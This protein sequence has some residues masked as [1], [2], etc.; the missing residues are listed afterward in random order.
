MIEKIFVE[1]QGAFLVK[2]RDNTFNGTI[3]ENAFEHINNFLK[4][5]GPLKIN[6]VSQD[7]FR[8]SVF[9]ISLAGATSESFKN[10][11]I[12]SVTTWENLIEKFVQ[13]FYQVSNDNEEMEAEERDD[14]DD[15]AEIFKIKGNL[16]DYETP[17]CKAFN[18]FNYILK[19]YMGLFTFDIQGISTYEEYE[20][21]NTMTRDLEEPWSDNGV[22]Y[23]LCEPYLFK[24]GMTK[25][26]TCSSDIDGFCNEGELPRMVRVGCMTYF[27]DHK[28]YDEL[29]DGKLKEETLTHKAKVEESWGDATPG[30][31]KLCAWLKNSF[32][33]FH[34]LDY[35]VLVKMQECWWKEHEKEH[36]DPSTCRVRRIEMIKYSFDADDEYVAIKEHEC[37][38]F[39]E[40]NIDTCQAYRELFRIMDEGWLVT[41]AY[42]E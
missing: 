22:P 15:I 21:N 9:P 17:L 25:W 38:E 41:K 16:F 24:N 37:F 35:N 39:L 7:R 27:Q 28:W 13:K 10:D 31:M 42:D 2:T 36:R 8:L 32:G 30:V 14:P 29:V 23:Q 4:V 18:D 5:V 19:I 40:T 1:I 3:R 26:P 6:G 20:L 34:E 12:G 33:N 11:C